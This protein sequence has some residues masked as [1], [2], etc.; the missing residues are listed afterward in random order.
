MIF[1][2]R[3]RAAKSVVRG[4]IKPKFELVR[5]FL[6]VLITCKNKEDPI[7]NEGARVITRVYVV[8]FFRGSRAANFA[9]SGKI[10]PK[11]ELI[12]AFMV[13]LVTRKNKEE[14]KKEGSLV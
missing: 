10:L 4:Q 12:Q 5:D 13:V 1:R 7:I 14:A 3:S 2:K 9:V 11:F 8:F 6:V